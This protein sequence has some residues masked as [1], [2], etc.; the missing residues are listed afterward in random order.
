MQ[1][2]DY[3]L[4]VIDPEINMSQPTIKGTELTVQFVLEQIA[5][6]S[7]NYK[8]PTSIAQK[9]FEAIAKKLL[10]ACPQLTPNGLMAAVNYARAYDEREGMRYPC[11]C[12]GYLVYSKLETYDICPICFWE[13]DPDQNRDPLLDGL[14]NKVSLVE[15]Q[16]NYLAFGACEERIKDYVRPP[17]PDERQATGW[18]PIDLEQDILD[19]PVLEPGRGAFFLQIDP[20]SRYYWSP[21]FWRR[22]MRSRQDT[23]QQQTPPSNEE[24]I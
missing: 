22:V 17:L 6:E 20:S 13:A 3:P 19:E 10:E 21:T 4:I 9:L 8:F 12:C 11:C 15:G 7:A 2:T 16:K 5:Q 14:A 24:K 1:Q 23:S 18:R